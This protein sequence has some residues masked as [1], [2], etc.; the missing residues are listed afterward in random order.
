MTRLPGNEF[1]FPPSENEI[2][3]SLFGPGYGESIALHLGHGD[4]AIVDSCI[5]KN[6][7]SAPLHYL[8]SIGVNPSIAV[9]LIV[10]THWHD[11][12][13]R[14]IASVVRNCP[15]AQFFCSDA[16][17]VEEFRILVCSLRERSMMNSTSGV[18]EFGDVMSVL[19][20][21]IAAKEKFGTPK[22]AVVDR[23]I[24]NRVP[25]ES[26][27]I[28][29]EV[30]SLSPSDAS[31]ILAKREIRSLIPQP[32]DSKL[33]IPS[34]S[35]NHLAV[36]LWIKVGNNCLLLGS[37]LENTSTESTGWISILESTARPNEKASIFKVPHHGSKTAFEERVW[38]DMLHVKPIAALTPFIRGNTA[39][40]T[41][42]DVEKVKGLS[43]Q[44]YLTAKTGTK[45]RKDRHNIVNKTIKETV[46]SICDV[47]TSTGVVRLRKVAAGSHQDAW[48]V[49]LFGSALDLSTIQA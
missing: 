18:K 40:P 20:E 48:K 30:W 46:L 8:R 31:I 29:A 12:H 25:S 16:L 21:R 19:E 32:G 1:E 9:K 39:L 27:S 44:A 5:N 43:G 37:D 2:E 4:W 38:Q 6:K 47:P 11:D 24:W 17:K 22:W 49:N 15:N 13:V 36:V 41:I 10:A 23:R 42:S 14:G 45:V 33:R 28:S 3:L 26:K 34:K 7:E 35:P